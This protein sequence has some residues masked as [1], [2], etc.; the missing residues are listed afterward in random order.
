MSTYEVK[1]STDVDTSELD[2]AQKKLDNLV[3]N[4]KQIKVDFNI[5]GMNNLNKINGMFKNIEK[6]NKINVKADM[7]TSGIKKGI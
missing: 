4:D 1:V 6:N 5:D 2:A 3:K 7:D